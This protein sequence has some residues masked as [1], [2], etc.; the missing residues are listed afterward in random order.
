MPSE[1]AGRS[2]LYILARLAGE[3]P[4][5]SSPQD[6]E[7]RNALRALVLEKM[8]ESLPR[9]M[10]T[11]MCWHGSKES[12]TREETATALG[13]SNRT[14]DKHLSTL[15][16]HA[17]KEFPDERRQLF[18]PHKTRRYSRTRRSSRS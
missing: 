17:N 3:S 11:A 6:E 4:C 2:D 9:E 10:G 16:I 18:G 15:R 14:V 5:T 1:A 13:V 7:E 12:R 8:W